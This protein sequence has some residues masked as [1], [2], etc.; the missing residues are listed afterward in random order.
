[1]CEKVSVMEIKF[2]P[3]P[4]I[5]AEMHCVLSNSHCKHLQPLPYMPWKDWCIIYDKEIKNQYNL[6]NYW[7]SKRLPECTKQELIENTMEFR[8]SEI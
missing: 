3:N 6:N 7:E 2:E 5:K 1:M 8:Y 4:N